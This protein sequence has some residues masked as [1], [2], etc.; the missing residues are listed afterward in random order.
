RPRRLD[1]E[2]VVAGERLNELKVVRVAPIPSSH[3]TA[4]Q[5]QIRMQDHALRVEELLGAE[6]IAGGAGARGVVERE[7]L[8]LERRDAVAADRAGMAAREDQLLPRGLLQE[9][10]P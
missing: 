9:G 10:E 4:R 5:R 7:E 3:R 6:A 2:A 8:R 1:V